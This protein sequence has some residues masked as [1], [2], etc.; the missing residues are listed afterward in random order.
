MGEVDKTIL[1]A[2]CSKI[3]PT[4]F[5][6]WTYSGEIIKVTCDDDPTLEWLKIKVPTSKTWERATPAVVRMDKLSKLTKAYLWIPGEAQ[7]DLDEKEDVLRRLKGQNPNL[8]VSKVTSTCAESDVQPLVDLTVMRLSIFLEEILISLKEQFYMQGFVFLAYKLPVKKYREKNRNGKNIEKERNLEIQKIFRNET[9]FGN[10]NDG[11]TSLKF[12]EDP[13]VASKI[14]GS[15]DLIYKLKVILEMISSGHITDPKKYDKYAFNAARLYVQL[16]S[17]HPITPTMHKILVHGTVIIKTELLPIEQLSEEAA[18]AHNSSTNLRVAF[19]TSDQIN[20]FRSL[21]LPSILFGLDIVPLLS[22][23]F[24]TRE[25]ASS[26]KID[27]AAAINNTNS[28]VVDLGHSQKFTPKNIVSAS[29][30]AGALHNAKALEICNSAINLENHGPPKNLPNIGYMSRKPLLIG[31]QQNSNVSGLKAADPVLYEY[32]YHAT[33]FAV[34][35]PAEELEKHLQK[36][37]PSV[38]V[39]KLNSRNPTK[40]SSFKISLLSSESN[41]ILDSNIWPSQVILNRFFLPRKSPV[42]TI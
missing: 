27:H 16:Y 18:E 39:Q 23:Y 6:S 2:S 7:A 38:K 30:V 35:A 11:N 33:N 1:S 42:N 17:W 26:T 12:F 14:M 34:D 28:T 15:Y 20:V 9:G 29:A 37:A 10:T 22:Y 19:R 3:K 25:Q 36:Y 5:R 4:T 40:H 13:K 24:H 8:Q 41:A 32:H 21:G 31:S